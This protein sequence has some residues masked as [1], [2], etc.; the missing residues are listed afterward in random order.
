M[1]AG[2]F[3][4]RSIMLCCALCGSACLFTA[5]AQWNNA[6]FSFEHLT[7]DDGL[8][9]S[10]VHD[11]LEDDLG[12]IWVGTRFGLNRYDGYDFKVFLPDPNDPYSIS[13]QSILCLDKDRDGNIWIGH[14]NGG[15]SVLERNSG[16]FHRFPYSDNNT[17]DWN[18]ISV[19]SIFH[20]SHDNIWLGTYGA[21]VIVFDSGYQEI[22]RFASS[23]DHI[24]YRLSNDFVFDF[25]ED[26]DGRIW[27]GTAG[28]GINVYDPAAKQLQFIHGN[29]AA[30]MDGFKKTICRGEGQTIWIGSE[31]SGLYEIDQRQ[32]RV[33]RHFGVAANGEPGLS[34]LMI[35]DLITDRKG[36]LWIASDGGGL[37]RFTPSTGEWQYFSYQP[38]Y[39]NSLNSDALYDLMLDRNDNL[40]IG[41]F[42]GGINVHAAVFPPFV[43]DRQYARES[44]VG[45]RSVLAVDQHADGAIYL[46]TD[47]GGLFRL[48]VSQKPIELTLVESGLLAPGVKVI[49]SLLV[50]PD[51]LLWLG[52]FARGLLLY[53]ESNGVVRHFT[54]SPGDSTSISHN[55]VW[56]IVTDKNGGLW[57][58]T[59]GGG[60]CYLKSDD[61]LFHRFMPQHGLSGTQI[62]DVLIDERRQCVWAA[63]ENAGLNKIELTSTPNRIIQYHHDRQDRQSLRS[64][65]LRCLY[66]DKAGTLWIGTED[67]G[68]SALPIESD[69]FIHYTI[70]DGLPSNMINSM[71]ESEDG[72]LWITTQAG[73]VKWNRAN[74]HFTNIG[75]E[76]FLKNNQYNPRASMRLR[77]GRLIMG[78]TNGYSIVMPDALPANRVPPA[79]IFTGFSISNETIPIGEFKGRYILSGPL[80]DPGTQ[81]KLSYLDKGVHIDF[82]ST[83]LIEANK[84]QFAYRLIGFDTTWRVVGPEQRFATFSALPGG[85]Y[86]LQV[87]AAN[88]DGTW[89]T[90]I[91]LLSI[92]VTPPFWTTWWFIAGMIAIIIGVMFTGILFLFSRQRSHFQQQAL[93]AEQEIL[94]L[95]N[96]NLA[97]DNMSKQAQLNA[98]VLQSAHKNQ[99]LEDVRKQIHRLENGEQLAHGRELNRLSRSI[100]QEITQK[101]YWDQFQLTFNQVHQDFAHNL[102]ASHP[103]ISPS[104]TRLCCFIRMGFS[105]AEIA[106]VLNITVNGVEQSKY[107][108]K[109]KLD[110]DK[111][112]SL[113]EYISA[114]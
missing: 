101:D 37:N 80:N 41:T 59:L 102:Q 23:S 108:L 48:D 103:N 4:L 112:V 91:R 106:S 18:T 39:L 5:V 63:S 62:L 81:I 68:L 113:N 87:K 9:Y 8:S 54:H 33:I 16:R 111:A 99:F 95:Q 53:S 17:L 20:D 14:L 42:N 24:N 77:D 69:T 44:A 82:A 26:D 114:I 15:V 58:A 7:V 19:R 65:N 1:N 43:I 70:A 52:T 84:N 100:E 83:D 46:G 73:I 74:N 96:E 90:S 40:W 21:G 47:G 97:K 85:S 88:S 32:M 109:K 71:V 110:L 98:S 55:N 79:V 38:G 34:H 56:D 45:L 67:A 27:I 2:H 89:S 60:V 22:A 86:Q 104:E 76:P 31:G 107:R 78:S 50:R 29:D 75:S 10:A 6:S 72:S 93:V 35:T 30:D 3:F 25:Y 94:R 11:L 13:S 66:Q 105:N 61:D 64:E 12:M 51:K 36:Q 92:N 49:T 57:I 28:T